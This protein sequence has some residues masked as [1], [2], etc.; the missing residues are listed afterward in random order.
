M[1]YGEGD[2]LGPP[3]M[4]SLHIVRAQASARSLNIPSFP[5]VK[6]MKVYES[7]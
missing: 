7:S 5:L 1:E 3:R 2:I 4:P 6:L